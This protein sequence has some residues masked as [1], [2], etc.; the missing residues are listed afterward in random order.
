MNKKE[1]IRSF[2]IK[3]NGYIQTS[4]VLKH[5]ISKQYFYSFVK[6][7]GLKKVAN[8]LYMSEDA[9]PD[10]MYVLQVR[11]PSLIFSHESAAYLMNIAEREPLPFSITLKAGASSSLLNREGLNVYK[12]KGELFEIGLINVSSPASH[13]LR[14]YNLE[15][16]ICDMIRNKK[17]IEIQDFQAAIKGYI[18]S[19]E[20]N[21]N[22]LMRYSKAFSIE[23]K[24]REYLEVLL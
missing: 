1:I 9:W 23:K 8:G 7:N 18:Q 11:Y 12:V 16:T 17:N 5:D 4:D 2:L 13:Q 24:V 19:K 20:K 10:E 14:C 22:Q 6:Q 21:I 3:N 15:R